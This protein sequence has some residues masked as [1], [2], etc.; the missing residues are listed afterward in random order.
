MCIGK[1]TPIHSL[2]Y[3]DYLQGL[4][5]VGVTVILYIRFE[6]MYVCMYVWTHTKLWDLVLSMG[7]TQDKIG[8]H[9]YH[10]IGMWHDFLHAYILY[11][12]TDYS[13]YS[14][15]MLMDKPQQ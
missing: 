13:Y 8:S 5:R 9:D 11:I 15:G 12:P 1:I 14:G 6:P 10:T 3:S 4:V 2:R 7:V